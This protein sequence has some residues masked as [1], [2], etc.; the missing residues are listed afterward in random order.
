MR[1]SKFPFPG[2]GTTGLEEGGG[3]VGS[4]KLRPGLGKGFSKS[5]PHQTRSQHSETITENEWFGWTE[6]SM[7]ATRKLLPWEQEEKTGL[8]RQRG[9]NE[10]YQ[11]AGEEVIFAFGAH[12]P[13]NI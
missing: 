5:E 4:T 13:I 8:Q 6:R 3:P 2:T 11:K 7:E 10:E 12:S 9:A 1:S